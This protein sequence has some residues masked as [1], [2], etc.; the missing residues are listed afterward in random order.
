MPRFSDPRKILKGIKLGF[1]APTVI[2][3]SDLGVRP[4]LSYT[5]SNHIS[6]S[7]THMENE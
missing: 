3:P 4:R 1:D 5:R 2:S 6:S 7:M